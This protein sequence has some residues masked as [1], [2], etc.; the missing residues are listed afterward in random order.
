METLSDL[1]PFDFKEFGTIFIYKARLVKH[2]PK[3][4]P[5]GII[6]YYRFKVIDLPEDLDRN[7][8]LKCSGS[9]DKIVKTDKDLDYIHLSCS[10]IIPLGTEVVITI[11]RLDKDD[12]DKVLY[13]I[14]WL[15]PYTEDGK[16]TVSPALMVRN[17]QRKRLIRSFIGS[18]QGFKDIKSNPTVVV[19]PIPLK[20]AL[21]ILGTPNEKDE[22]DKKVGNSI[23]QREIQSVIDKTLYTM[24]RYF[25]SKVNEDELIL[26][27]S[28]YKDLILSFLTKDSDV[29]R[30]FNNATI[31]D[32]HVAFGVKELVNL[33]GIRKY[34]NVIRKCYFKDDY[35]SRVIH[36]FILS[37]FLKKTGRRFVVICCCE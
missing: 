9:G 26:K 15:S 1:D 32:D 12:S 2:V 4:K 14:I 21:K 33:K 11:T 10:T 29:P 30:E 35:P 25:I 16:A 8:I 34:K 18:N 6:N 19:F 31:E 37:M 7:I 23:T 27:S 3:Q 20:S 24:S 36:Y 5:K 28:R 22:F 17:K 13:N